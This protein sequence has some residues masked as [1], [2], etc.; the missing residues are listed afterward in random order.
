[1]RA[2]RIFGQIRARWPPLPRR[3]GRAEQLP[4]ES[5]GQG[6]SRGPR[7]QQ[8]RCFVSTPRPRR[9]VYF[10]IEMSVGDFCPATMITLMI[11]FMGPSLAVTRIAP[12]G[13]GSFTIGG[14]KERP[15]IIT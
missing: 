12:A 7:W 1:M 10:F 6:I 4:D 2:K 5:Q 9:G 14:T 3:T 8:H 11:F 15:A 13:K